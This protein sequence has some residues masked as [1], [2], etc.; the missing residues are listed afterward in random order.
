MQLLRLHLRLWRL[1]R[2]PH[3]HLH[4]LHNLHLLHNRHRRLSL[5]LYLRQRQ[6]LNLHLHQPL[7]QLQQLQLQRELRSRQVFRTNF[8]HQLCVV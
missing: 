2:P 5:C 4:P 7:D 3:L 1:R 8:F 6:L